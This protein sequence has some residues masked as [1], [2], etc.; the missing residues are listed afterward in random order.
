[1][2]SVQREI[3]YS[4]K[5]GS[6]RKLAENQFGFLLILPALTLLL[7]MLMYPT[8]NSIFISFTN[9][10]PLNPDTE[11]IG[12]DNYVSIL[13]NP[14]YKGVFWNTLVLT[15]FATFI[16]FVLGFAWAIV[17]NHGFRSS[18][19]LRGSTLI[20]WIIPGTC[21]GFIWMWI[22]NG[23]YGILNSILDALGLIDNNLTLL[24]HPKTAMMVIIISS[25]WRSLPWYMAFLLG[26]LQAVPVE[27]VEAARLD[28]AGNFNVLF[29]IVIPNMKG[30]INSLLILGAIGSLQQFD[31]IWVMTQGGPARGTT[32]LAI[33]V[34][35]N[36][37]QN[38]NTGKAAAIG[39]LWMLTLSIFTYFYMK[40]EKENQ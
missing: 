38:W 20:A 15:F 28:G 25:T 10:S 3:S 31:L 21:I 19:F 11:F 7:V 5:M 8:L 32:T 24:G 27:Q 34:Y 23:E 18:Q 37:F 35:K 26:G 39:V 40:T 12:F 4:R 33:E 1:M 2:H 17:L 29:H 36:A 22:F 30:L 9:K 16:P 14:Q 13:R 6:G